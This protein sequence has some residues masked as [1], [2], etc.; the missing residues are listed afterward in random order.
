M[1]GIATSDDICHY[2]WLR[3]SILNLIT[4]ETGMTKLF[5][6]IR[7]LSSTSM[8]LCKSDYDWMEKGWWWTMEG[9]DESYEYQTSL[10]TGTAL[11]WA[12]VWVQWRYAYHIIEGSLLFS[13][14]R[15]VK[16]NLN[17]KYGPH[18]LYLPHR[19]Q[20][21]PSFKWDDH[22]HVFC[23]YQWTHHRDRYWFEVLIYYGTKDL[24]DEYQFFV[25]GERQ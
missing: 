12:M 10:C 15:L 5:I 17:P 1:E 23:R 16:Y 9:Y 11:L 7:K 25:L 4:G 8:A 19:S 18:N 21:H 22:L 24:E 2:Q 14:R 6:N 13:S 20:G 3:G